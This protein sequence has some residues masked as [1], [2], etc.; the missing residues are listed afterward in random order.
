VSDAGLTATSVSERRSGRVLNVIVIEELEARFFGD[1]AA[2]RA[3]HP[4]VPST[5]D[6]KAGFRDPD[7][8]VDPAGKLEG[9]LVKKGEH[10]GGL[11]KIR[12]A[13]DIAGHLDPDLNQSRSF[14]RFRDGVRLLTG[15]G[16]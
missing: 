6:R 12:A 1:N 3:A 13:T 15:E 8:T 11:Q 10:R 4:K 5:L 14:Q 2:L 9:I 7:A 16:A